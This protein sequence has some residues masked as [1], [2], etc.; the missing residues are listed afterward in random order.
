MNELSTAV[1]MGLCFWGHF[2]LHGG[3]CLNSG[4]VVLQLYSVGDAPPQLFAKQGQVP[5]TCAKVA[6][7]H[8]FQSAC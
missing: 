7:N 6:E 8:A 2:N 3:K 5:Y 4:S 1:E